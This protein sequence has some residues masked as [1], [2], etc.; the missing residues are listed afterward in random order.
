MIYIE[1]KIP[2]R[3]VLISSHDNFMCFSGTRYMNII[4]NKYLNYCIKEL[5]VE[6]CC[7]MLCCQDFSLS[8]N[9]SSGSISLQQV[10]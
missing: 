2:G 6:I 7:L 9:R 8:H 10:P 4:K 1:E 5:V 3:N